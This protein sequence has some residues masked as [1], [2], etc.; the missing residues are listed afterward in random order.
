MKTIVKF[1]VLNIGKYTSKQAHHMR[2]WIIGFTSTL[3]FTDANE[4]LCL[5]YNNNYIVQPNTSLVQY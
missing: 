5:V 4:R 3:L 2:D 1:S